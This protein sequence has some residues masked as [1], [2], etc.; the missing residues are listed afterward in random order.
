MVVSTL[1]KDMK[2]SKVLWGRV[3]GKIG[4]S[5]M[6]MAVF[7]VTRP[8]YAQAGTSIPVANSHVD[9]IMG[10]YYGLSVFSPIIAAVILVFLCLIYLFRVIAKATFARWAFSVIVAG[11]ALYISNMLFYIN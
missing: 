4:F 1:M 10:I 9:V 11:A 8:S 6:G 2:Y 7:P 5:F 3:G